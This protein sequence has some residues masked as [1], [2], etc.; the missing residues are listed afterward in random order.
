M[1]S[2][3][4]SWSACRWS[5][6]QLSHNSAHHCHSFSLE[7]VYS[8]MMCAKPL[9]IFCDHCLFQIVCYHISLCKPL[10]NQIVFFHQYVCDF[11]WQMQGSY[12]LGILSS[13][14]RCVTLMSVTEPYWFGVTFPFI[15]G[16]VVVLDY[17]KIF[18]DSI[19]AF[20]HFGKAGMS[21]YIR[22]VNESHHFTYCILCQFVCDNPFKIQMSC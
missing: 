15:R 9:I 21:S 18:T 6:L 7:S 1:L 17:C 22:I 5:S 19:M 20:L 12:W 16:Y 2:I 3:T 8:D 4:L 13:Y 14:R 11:H 10:T